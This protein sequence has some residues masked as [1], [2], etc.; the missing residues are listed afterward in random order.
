[1]TLARL[2]LE[3]ESGVIAGVAPLNNARQSRRR[4]LLDFPNVKPAALVTKRKFLI[5]RHRICGEVAL[6]EKSQPLAIRAVERIQ[7][8][9][10]L[11]AGW[12]VGNLDLL[13][14]KCQYRQQ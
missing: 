12:R 7:P 6:H 1:V 5:Q 4:R 2:D 9:R 13:R 8:T 10:K 11:T 3:H 14:A